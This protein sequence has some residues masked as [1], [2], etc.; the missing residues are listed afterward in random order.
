MEIIPSTNKRNDENPGNE[1]IMK[2]KQLYIFITSKS[3]IT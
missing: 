1:K 3:K 2:T